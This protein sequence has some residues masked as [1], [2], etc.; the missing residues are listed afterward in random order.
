[1]TLLTHGVS[2]VAYSYRNDPSVP[3]FP[4]DRPIIFFD[5]YCVLCSGFARFVLRNDRQGVFRLAAAQSSLGQAVYRHFGLDP[6]A[7]ESNL[8]LTDGRGWVKSLGT[9]RIFVRLGFPW[10]AAAILKLIPRTL[11]DGLY[12]VIARNRIRWFGANSVCLL[13]DPGHSDRFLQ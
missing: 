8:L 13:Q 2:D 5:G 3:Q 10:S 1:M 6:V 4:D 9:I 11:I 7:F 12:D